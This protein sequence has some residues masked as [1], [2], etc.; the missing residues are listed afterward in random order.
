V[1]VRACVRLSVC[2]CVCVR[3]HVCLH[4]CVIVH[5]SDSW[6]K[7]YERY[8]DALPEHQRLFLVPAHA[9]EVFEGAFRFTTS[10]F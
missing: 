8:L 2:A 4:I 3:V 1:H 6:E 7:Q 9:L 5:R 10:S